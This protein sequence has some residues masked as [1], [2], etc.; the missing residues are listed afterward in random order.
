MF[1]S[2]GFTLSQLELW[3][4]VFVRFFTLLSVMP[5]F[6]YDSLDPRVRAFLAVLLATVMAKIIPYPDNFPIV[7]TMLMFYVAREVLIGLCIGMFCSFFVEIVK[8]AGTQTSHMMGLNMASLIDPTTSEES[9][10]MP[11]LYN[12]LAVLLIL[13]ID[14]HHFFLRILLES[15]YMIPVAQVEFPSEIVPQMI[16]IASN[17]VIIGIRLSAPIVISVFLV[18][19]IVGFMN[20][21]V[22]EADVFSVIM[23]VNILIGLYILSYY[24]VYF[25]QIVNQIYI[26]TQ[27]KVLIIFRLLGSNI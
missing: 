2:L 25:A 5:F 19:I 9:E 13:S 12:I 14:G 4:L 27:E 17:I 8:F 11:E 26:L 24:W 18:R 1:E 3:L 15:F 21:L 22:Q 10:A 20:R 7:F 6:S 23:V 16:D